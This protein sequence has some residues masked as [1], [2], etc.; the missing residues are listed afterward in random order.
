MITDWTLVTA[1]VDRIV[2]EDEYPSASQAGIVDQLAADAFSHLSTLWATSL[3]PGLER[4]QRRALDYT[5]VAFADLDEPTQDELLE[6]LANDIDTGSAESVEG[7]YATL[8]RLVCEHYYGTRGAASWKMLGYS[9]GLRRSSGLTNPPEDAIATVTLAEVREMYDI[10]VV[11]LGA[12]GGVAAAALA[13][14][15]ARVLGID[16]GHY[17]TYEQVGKEHLRNFRLST[18]GHNTPPG[19]EAGP[20]VVQTTAGEVAVENPWE[21]GWSALPQTIGGGTRVYQGMAWRLLPTDFRLATTYGTPQGSSLADWPIGYADVEPFYDEIEWTL[22]VSGDATGHR[23]QGP[24]RRSYPMGPLPDNSEARLLRRGAERLGLSTGAVPMLINSE[25]RDGRGRCGQCGECVGFACPTAAKNG[26]YNTVL[27]KAMA[28]GNLTLAVGARALHIVTDTTGRVTGARILDVQTGQQR[29][30]RA[31]HVVVACSAIET[32]RLLLLS[33]S[34]QHPTGLG[35]GHDQVGRHLQGHRYVGAFGQFDETVIDGAG[36]NVRIATCDFIHPGG[37]L[38]GGVLANETVK[39][40]ILHWNWALPP[41]APRSG[42]AAK[43]AMAQ[44]YRRTSHIFGPIQEIPSADARVTL[45]D[46]LA[47]SQGQPVARITGRLHPENTRS[48]DFLISKAME[49]LTSSGARRVW[50]SGYS[51]NVSAGQH[52]AGTCRMGNDPRTSVTDAQGRVH[53]HDN[54]WVADGSVHVTNGGFN[55]VLTILALALRTSR[56]LVQ[57]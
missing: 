2:P 43:R 40:P 42:L 31:G 32:A 13:Q 44:L 53:G 41:D 29:T 48:A 49:W 38:L 10:L 36:P 8:V 7:W 19:K 11:G 16:R 27:P 1:V 14:S 23:N 30:I 6:E 3:A 52:Q 39:L 54:L 5:G 35:N 9:P 20:R 33:R 56:N 17:L 28:S 12:G 26:P 18:Y 51:M 4:L 46:G 57:S 25:P 45:A 21:P 22:G 34:P 55:P 37:G 47:D 24:R 15:G 50:S